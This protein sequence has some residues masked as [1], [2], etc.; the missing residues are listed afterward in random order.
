[1][2]TYDSSYMGMKSLVI[3]Q[4]SVLPRALVW[5]L[6]CGVMGSVI[7]FLGVF[8]AGSQ[9]DSYEALASFVSFNA[10][11]GFLVI[12]RS[13]QAYSRYWEGL[14][15]LQQVRGQWFNATSSLFAFC[16]VKPE[17]QEVV[18]KFRLLQVR[19]TSLLYCAG[20]RRV[21]KMEDDDF[22]VIEVEGIDADALQY[23]KEH[24]DPC[25]VIMQWIQQLIVS[26]MR[27]GVLDI[28]A[29]V[30]SR[31]F[32]EL[33]QG[34]VSLA[35]AQK[36]AD[37]PFPFSSAQMIAA[38][39]TCQWFMA[40]IISASITSSWV[41]SGIASFF[42]VFL[43][44]CL[45]L[46][47]SEI[48]MPFGDD[49]NDLP[50]GEMQDIMNYNLKTLLHRRANQ[51]PEFERTERTGD[52]RLLIWSLNF[53]ERSSQCDTSIGLNNAMLSY[54]KSRRTRTSRRRNR[55]VRSDAM[56]NLSEVSVSGRGTS[57]QPIDPD[58]KPEAPAQISLAI[59]P[60]GAPR[61]MTTLDDSNGDYDEFE[62]EEKVVLTP[63]GGTPMAGKQRKRVVKHTSSETHVSVV[64][65]IIDP[66]EG[67]SNRPSDPRAPREPSAQRVK[68]ARQ[69][70]KQAA[71]H[72]AHRSSDVESVSTVS[73]NT[74]LAVSSASRTL[75][76]D[77]SL[78]EHSCDPTV[79]RV[80]PL[81]S[82][83][84]R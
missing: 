68:G 38:M 79:E 21:A 15:L 17:L 67:E 70:R 72:L 66:W 4:G 52:N 5:A 46:M 75:S 39:M 25:V 6:P 53:R 9:D 47:A 7:S 57:S 64:E 44:S 58:F 81:R 84:D 73:P 74:A 61:P 80:L 29:P 43:I 60:E 13:Q 1:M 34:I 14:T 26:N 59:E 2:I 55:S 12:F 35:D 8:G 22:Q 82:A 30:I 23:M 19:L 33:S 11:L 78:H 41:A 18:S 49:P 3:M 10:I 63:K 50:L 40:P 54:T 27:Q 76:Q 48:E 62:P 45:N 42:T 65:E 77:E 56:S 83:S 32:Q 69:N 37:T 16:T 24:P 28:P 31:V 71:Q 36:I 20:L 51:V